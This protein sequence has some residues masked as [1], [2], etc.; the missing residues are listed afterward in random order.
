M[1]PQRANPLVLSELGVVAGSLNP[2]A[3]SLSKQRRV[4][5]LTARPAWPWRAAVADGT[6]AS[7]A[8][9]MDGVFCYGGRCRAPDPAGN[10]GPHGRLLRMGE[11]ALAANRVACGPRVEAMPTASSARLRF[12]VPPL[13]RRAAGGFAEGSSEVARGRGR[14]VGVAVAFG[15][16]VGGRGVP[17]SP[18]LARL[19]PSRRPP[20]KANGVQLAELA[21]AS[22][23]V[24][25][26]AARLEKIARLAN[27]LR[28][29]APEE[30]LA[31][32]SWLAGE[33]RQGRIGL[34]PAAVRGALAAT[35][36]ARDGGADR[37]RRRRGARTDRRRG[38]RAGSGGERA[39]LLAALFARATAEERDFLARLALGELR[40]G[41]LE[42]VLV[43]AVARAAGVPPAMCAAR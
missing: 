33:L 3:L 13:G 38:A 42:G 5:G 26:T 17:D 2:L 30:R 9:T 25:G 21:R 27:A 7:S 23:A 40:Q 41:A 35:A 31:G 22:N 20:V 12:E 8:G 19:R 1:Q 32:A 16:A 29:L 37:R 11:G 43:E 4:L 36:P 15:V 24:A 39:R 10:A 34:G 14:G 28:A 18:H 6:S